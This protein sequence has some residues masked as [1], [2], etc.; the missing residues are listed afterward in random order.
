DDGGVA[1]LAGEARAPSTRKKR[2]LVTSASRNRL[3]D[4]LDRM[5]HDDANRD[6]PVVGSVGG[7]KRSAAGVEAHVA[8]YPRAQIALEQPV[9][10]V[11]KAPSHDAALP[12]A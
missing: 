2:R 8:G 7:V 12:C 3:D 9:I 10:A 1:A 5:R 11:I 6:L 4:V